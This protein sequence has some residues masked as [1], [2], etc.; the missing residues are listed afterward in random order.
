ME[1]NMFYWISWMYWV[2]LTFILDKQWP[3]RRRLSA[4]ILVIIILSTLHF[5]VSD[6]DI[7]VSSIVLLMAAYFLISREKRTSI[8][9]I[10][11]CSFI[12][13]ISYVT[14]HLFEIFD[15]IWVIFKADWMIAICITI[16]SLLLQ[17][18]LKGRL[19]IA[20]SGTMQGEILYA[21]ILNKYSFPYVIGS[22]DYLDVC[23]LISA[24]LVGWSCLENAGSYFGNHVSALGNINKNHHK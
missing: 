11:V 15:P 5:K 1:G 2:L 3:Y 12:I 24:L 13:T 23:F 6:F 10:L 21:Y 4:S 7:Y 14:F 19:L 20:I 9:Y 22:F 18:K 17:N 8:F 16:L